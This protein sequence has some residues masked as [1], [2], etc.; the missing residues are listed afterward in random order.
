M[1]NFWTDDSQFN[2]YKKKLGSE[3]AAV[4]YI[5]NLARKKLTSVDNVILESE[6]IAWASSGV[7][8]KDIDKYTQQKSRR[9]H[10]DLD[11]VK[12]RLSY[13]LDEGVRQAVLSTLE[14]S[15]L[16]LI[17]IYNDVDDP[18]RQARIR[19]LSNLIW[20]ELRQGHI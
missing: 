3:F 16:H 8:P 14:T 11:Y 20:D 12:D 5:S 13:V 2:R 17:Y 19:I 10:Q 6:A 9:A 15:T 18:F 4:L 1:D 7:P